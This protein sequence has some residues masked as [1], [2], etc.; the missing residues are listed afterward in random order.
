MLQAWAQMYRKFVQIFKPTKKVVSLFWYQSAWC[1]RL[2]LT[3]QVQMLAENL[4]LLPWLSEQEVKLF[5][6]R[7]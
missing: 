7:L 6:S 4:I 1:L 2:T 5:G 3:S